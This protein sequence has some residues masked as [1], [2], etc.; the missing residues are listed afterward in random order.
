MKTQLKRV[1]AAVLL[2]SLGSAAFAATA[3]GGYSPTIT[4][5]APPDSPAAHMSTPTCPL[6]P[7][8]AW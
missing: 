5:G 6:R 1:A 7:T 3:H 8:A 4:S 2:A